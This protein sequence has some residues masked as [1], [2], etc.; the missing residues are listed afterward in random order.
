[1]FPE[2]LGLE[3]HDQADP[4]LS[5]AGR[6]SGCASFNAA[7]GL[8]SK[9]TSPAAFVT[10]TASPFIEGLLLEDQPS[11][12]LTFH[13][14]PPPPTQIFLLEMSV[15]PTPPTP[16]R[17]ADWPHGPCLAKSIQELLPG[18]IE[19]VAKQEPS[20]QFA[21]RS[22]ARLKACPSSSEMRGLSVRAHVRV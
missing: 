13:G 15:Q 8:R 14:Q 12:N 16:S 21:G 19:Q 18:C 4:P 9:P 10:V 20:S 3:K 2:G 17:S 7:S 11:S 1:M 6:L 22:G 5:R